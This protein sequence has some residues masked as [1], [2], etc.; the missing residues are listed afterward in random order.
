LVVRNMEYGRGNGEE[1]LDISIRIKQTGAP[2][3]ARY[4]DIDI[5]IRINRYKYQDQADGCSSRAARLD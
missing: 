4:L 5:S 1:V 2:S 3:A